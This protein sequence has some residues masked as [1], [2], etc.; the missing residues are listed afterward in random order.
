MA[1]AT[2]NRLGILLLCLCTAALLAGLTACSK[3][4]LRQSMREAHKTLDK[5]SER[6]KQQPPDN[7][8]PVAPMPVPPE[9]PAKPAGH[10]K[11]SAPT[12]EAEPLPEPTQEDLVEYLRGKLLTLSPSDG[13]NDNVEVRFNASTSTLTVIQPT[14]RCDLFLSAL[15]ASN[16]TWDTFDPSDDQNPRPVLLR[17]TA[18]SVSG[19]KARACFDIRG[20]PEDGTTTNR[21]R[22]LFSLAKAE[23]L[24]GFQD[25]MTKTMKALILL[26]GGVEEQ[27]F[28]PD[29][30]AKPHS[31]NK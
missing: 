21:V 3:Y 2:R 24:P 23:Q 28:F 30:K 4:D 31:K 20:L 5:L 7:A 6:F 12:A 29:P 1:L 9:K 10:A 8:L 16:I 22:L 17:L 27:D 26:S 14:S 13:F 18:A 25:K 15:D 19:K 11:A